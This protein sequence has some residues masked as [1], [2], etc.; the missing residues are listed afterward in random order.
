MTKIHKKSFLLGSFLVLFSLILL[1][2]FVGQRDLEI[3]STLPR[4]EQKSQVSDE[5]ARVYR[6]ISNSGTSFVKTGN[7]ALYPEPKRNNRIKYLNPM[8][9]VHRIKTEGDWVRV[10]TIYNETAWI[11][12]SDLSERWIFVSKKERTVSLLNGLE[13][14]ATFNADFS[15][16]IAGDKLRQGRSERPEDWRTPEGLFYIATKKNYSQYYKALLINYPS[17]KHATRAIQS[18]EISDYQFSEIL[19]AYRRIEAPPMN[20]PLGG[21]IEIHGDGTGGELNW[22]KG[23]VAIENDHLDYVF[24]QVSEGTPVWIEARKKV[25]LG[26]ED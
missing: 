3:R 14:E 21:L 17:V 20:T 13:I 9:R 23:C 24:S 1:T 12:K 2:G 5:I 15:L 4:I 6:L 10:R 7:A 11:P 26:Q 16:F 22:T 8:D 18:N 25:I 19:R